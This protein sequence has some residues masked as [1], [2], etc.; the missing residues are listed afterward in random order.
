M[1]FWNIAHLITQ[2][3]NSIVTNLIDSNNN[4]EGALNDFKTY[5]TS[6]KD[7]IVE[8]K[9]KE[10]EL[11]A[12]WEKQTPASSYLGDMFRIMLEE[13]SRAMAKRKTGE[14]PVEAGLCLEYFLQNKV[15]D[16]LSQ[17]AIDNNP[18]GVTNIVIEQLTMLFKKLR[19]SLLSSNK[20]HECISK[21]IDYCVNLYLTENIDKEFEKNIIFFIQVICDKVSENP[22][23]INFFFHQGDDKISTSF[24]LVEPLLSHI[25]NVTSLGLTARKTILLLAA[26]PDTQLSVFLATKTQLPKYLSLGLLDIV[27]QVGDLSFNSRGD[28]EYANKEQESILSTFQNRVIFIS[29][30]LS[31]CE[32]TAMYK[33]EGTEE[34][35]RVLLYA[36]L[37]AIWTNVLNDHVKTELLAVHNVRIEHATYTLNAL[38]KLLR[39]SNSPL[40]S[41]LLEFLFKNPEDTGLLT[42]SL[43]NRIDAVGESISIS[44]MQL[45][46]TV[47]Q[48]QHPFVFKYLINFNEDNAQSSVQDPSSF[49]RTSFLSRLSL[50][51]SS[52]N[53]SMT[54]TDIDAP[55]ANQITALSVLNADTTND[56]NNNNNNNN[57]NDNNNTKEVSDDKKNSDNTNITD[58][59]NESIQYIPTNFSQLNPS[60]FA[61]YLK[62]AEY[63]YTF[64]ELE[65]SRKNKD[66]VLYAPHFATSIEQ[67]QSDNQSTLSQ[68]FLQV[69][70]NRL[71]RSLRQSCQLNLEVSNLLSLLTYILSESQLYYIYVVNDEYHISITNILRTI[72]EETVHSSTQYTGYDK[73]LLYTR[74][75]LHI[76]NTKEF[77]PI[78]QPLANHAFTIA[79]QGHAVI[80]EFIKELASIL[81]VRENYEIMSIE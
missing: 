31:I 53:P 8:L 49:T 75:S 9:Q 50:P 15:M 24:P 56:N 74:Q 44:T 38:F 61:S 11:P 43:V 20:V 41:I 63:K 23:M 25:Y 47:L 28:P 81:Q 64:L 45:F 51:P 58:E 71:S 76:V 3:F 39:N 19:Y 7:C 29:E 65:H 42:D 30:L 2:N 14:P 22:L 68:K 27:Q 54:T 6:F 32:S 67:N 72:L 48:L 5:W 59:K 33:E 13:E 12:D 10:N 16:E 52:I 18:K 70:C 78:D 80:E 66:Y 36:I 17:Y 62:D 55:S 57:N 37:K 35:K 40:T 34:E 73:Y 79:L 60:E 46:S 1:S 26:F 4:E 69:L 77:L 21:L